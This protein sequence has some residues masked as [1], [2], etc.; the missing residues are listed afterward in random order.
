VNENEFYRGALPMLKAAVTELEPQVDGVR[1]KLSEPGGSLVLSAI[2]KIPW[3][4]TD[5]LQL[6][7]FFQNMDG[8]EI[9]DAQV[10]WDH[11]SLYVEASEPEEGYMPATSENLEHQLSELPRLITAFK[12]AVLR[13]R[14]GDA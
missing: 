3:A 10:I 11:D 1:F 6:I 13:G 2:F 5:Q 8:S 12:T 9:V 4:G 14:P 7:I